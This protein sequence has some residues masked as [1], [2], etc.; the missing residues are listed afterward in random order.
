MILPFKRGSKFQYCIYIFVIAFVFRVFIIN[1][2]HTDTIAPD[3]TGYHEIT[4]NYC[5]GLGYSLHE[6]EKYFFREPGYP[7]FLSLSFKISKLFGNKT[8]HLSIDKD[9][10]IL[11]NAPEITIAKYLQALL[12]S[13][14]CVLFFLLIS[15]ILK[16]K[17]ASLIAISFC[18]Y[19]P[20]AIHV[21]DILRETLQSFLALG[22]CYALLRYFIFDKTKYLIVTG[23]LWGLLNLIFQVSLILA[24]S[25]PIFILIYKKNFI[26]AIRPS[27]IVVVVMLLTVS[28]WLIRSY[29]CYPDVRILKSFGTSLTPEYRNYYGSLEKA[30]YYGFVSENQMDSIFRS[31][32]VN[33]SE[34]IRFHHSWDGTIAQKTDSINT[35]VNEP[36]ISKRKIKQYSISFYKAWFP[37]KIVDIS[38]KVFIK[39]RPLLAII[40]ILPVLVIS[41]FAFLGLI[42]YYPKFFNINIVFTTFIPLFFILGTEYRRMLPVLPFIFL[43]GM[44]GIIYFYNKCFKAYDND[45]IDKSI[46]RMKNL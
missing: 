24:I 9:Y 16:N 14:A 2:Y 3:G 17:Y 36:F 42:K 32:L 44:M 21:T 22:M 18:F 46:F 23:V 11:N 25:I 5:E 30:A 26:K 8:E 6:G 4:Y 28:P 40:L 37:T 13:F 41:L 19:Y 7:I 29:N 12:D 39:N 1:F 20:Y 38:T 45:A 34:S 27:I 43:Y 31:D 10:K 35:L 15:N 33:V